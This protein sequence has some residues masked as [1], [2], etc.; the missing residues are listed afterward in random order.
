M[1]NPDKGGSEYLNEKFTNARDSLVEAPEP[2]K[3]EAPKE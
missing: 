3:Q 1:N 2:P